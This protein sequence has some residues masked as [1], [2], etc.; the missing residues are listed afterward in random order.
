MCCCAPPAMKRVL[1]ALLRAGV[2]EQ[3]QEERLLTTSLQQATNHLRC[4]A[5]EALLQHGA[6]VESDFLVATVLAA[7]TQAVIA[8]GSEAQRAALQ[9]GERLLRLLLARDPPPLSLGTEAEPA[10]P[11][12]C[13]LH[14]MVQH[15]IEYSPQVRWAGAGLGLDCSGSVLWHACSVYHCS[16]PD[17]PPCS[18]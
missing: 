9:R 17:E 11:F 6:R 18:I 1:A 12:T 13:P 10:G 4:S 16:A 3:G 14:L 7:C 2:V 15:T 5:A 8:D